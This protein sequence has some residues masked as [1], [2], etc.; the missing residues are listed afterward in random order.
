MGMAFIAKSLFKEKDPIWSLVGWFGMTG[1][2]F[3]TLRGVSG[4]LYHVNHKS[5]AEAPKE[6]V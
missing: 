2:W 5:D 3:A 6:Y 4:I 1:A